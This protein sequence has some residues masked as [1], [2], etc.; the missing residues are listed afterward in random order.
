MKQTLRTELE[1]MLSKIERRIAMLEENIAS[2]KIED[3]FEGAMKNQI[4]M[5]TLILI[6]EDLQVILSTY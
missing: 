1:N 6:K 5:N 2:Y 4:K 3:N